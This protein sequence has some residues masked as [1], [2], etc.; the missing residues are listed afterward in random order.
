M[1]HGTLLSAALLLTV[2]LNANVA[3][4]DA[5]LA[6][7]N[8]CLACHSIDNKIVGP[9]FKDVAAKYAGQA[10]ARDALIAKVKAGGS[11]NWGAVP[12]PSQAHV[13]EENIAILVDWI[14]SM[15]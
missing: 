10:D 4:A 5:Q 1:K 7:S 3:L 2:G 8:A 15:K 13:G 6:G 12:M 14:L 11:G 9:G